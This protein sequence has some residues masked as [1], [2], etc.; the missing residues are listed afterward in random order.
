MNASSLAMVTMSR[1]KGILRSVTGSQV[2]NAAAIAGKA[3]FLAP[4]ILTVPCSDFPPR[5]LNLSIRHFPEPLLLS[6]HPKRAADFHPHR[7]K[8]SGPAAPKFRVSASPASIEDRGCF[9]A[10]RV[11]PRTHPSRWP[12]PKF[13]SPYP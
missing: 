5:I 10:E 6:I 13:V 8:S 4:L 2:S 9:D 3:E 1:T 7:S 11:P 12:V